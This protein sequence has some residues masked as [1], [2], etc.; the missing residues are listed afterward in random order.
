K[1]IEGRESCR[2]YD[3]A[4]C[5][6]LQILQEIAEAG[7]AVPSACNMQPWKFLFISS[8]ELLRKVKNSY[9]SRWVDNAPHFLVVTGKRS[10]A[11]VR[12]DGYNSL[13]TDLT[14]AMDHMI[15]AAESLGVATCWIAA[16]DDKKLRK[17]LSLNEEEEV[18]AI[19]PLGYLP[20]GSEKKDNKIRKPLNKIA[21]FL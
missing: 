6:P 21:F 1:V 8:D 13:E 7:Q 15:L 16:F 4:K 2:I 3:P 20:A 14:I 12:S 19:T 10:A 17:A 9:G 18:F 5:D 11:W